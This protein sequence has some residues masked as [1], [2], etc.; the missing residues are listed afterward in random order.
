MLLRVSVVPGARANQLLWESGP[1]LRV[2]VAA[3]P[4]EGRANDELISFL[5]S[6]LGIPRSRVAVVKGAR[7][8]YKVIE[9]DGLDEGSVF[10]RLGR[11]VR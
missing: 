3:P 7:S 5:A 4:S 8:R 2:R 10:L 6:T 11:D 9:I 1:T